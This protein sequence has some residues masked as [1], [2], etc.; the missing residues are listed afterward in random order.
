MKG[1]SSISKAQSY[2]EIGE[3]WDAHD[4]TDYWDETKP[5]KF[6]VEITSQRIQNLPKDVGVLERQAPTAEKSANPTNPLLK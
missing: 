5:V 1:K 4:V 6:E 3:F 2:R